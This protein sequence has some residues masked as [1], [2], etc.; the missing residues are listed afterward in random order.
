M[1]KLLSLLSLSFFSTVLL[2]SN[3]SLVNGQL[4]V[5]GLHLCNEHNEV[6]QLKGMSSHGIQWYGWNKCLTPASLNVLVDDF[7]AT[8]LRVSLYVQENGYETNPVAFTKQVNDII[9]TA[10]QLGLYVIVDWHM[11]SPGDPDF[12]LERAK[13]FFKDIAIANQGRTNLLYEIANEPSGVHWTKIKN[14]ANELIPWIRGYDTHTPILLGTPAWSSLG[15]SA[16]NEG[17]TNDIIANPV[18][19]TNVMYTFHF[20][21]KEHQTTYLNALK[22]AAQHLP[23]FVTEWGT[24]EAS[25][26]GPNDFQMAGQ[27]IDYMNSQHISW[28]NW[29]YSDDKR[30]GAVWTEGT[31]KKGNWTDNH[32]KDAGKWVKCILSK[33]PAECES[34]VQSQ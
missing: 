28:V 15:V 20:Y 1:K 31:C 5:C 13:T 25:G 11:L 7:K 6:I 24:Q 14:Y 8:V 16:S 21:A 2:A 34:V 17:K 27:Y 33:P 23:I 12:N 18:N 9:E 10:S 3:F 29:N 19:D 26:D 30:T 4:H 22:Y 32:L